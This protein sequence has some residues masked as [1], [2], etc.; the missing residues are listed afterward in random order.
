MVDHGHSIN[1]VHQQDRL[2][3]CQLRPVFPPAWKECGAV[4][5][6]GGAARLQTGIV[7]WMEQMIWDEMEYSSR[8]FSL[9]QS[10]AF[11]PLSPGRSAVAHERDVILPIKGKC[12]C[13][14]EA[15]LSGT[16]LLALGLCT[17]DRVLCSWQESG[18]SLRDIAAASTVRTPYA[19]L[20]A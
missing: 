9:S 12:T 8:G 1:V 3:S 4:R 17:G 14:L 7:H 2:L 5:L 13:T 20:F 11:P 15:L 18:T 10:E 16:W 6:S 19:L